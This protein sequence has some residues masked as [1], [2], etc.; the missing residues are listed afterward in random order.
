MFAEPLT[1]NFLTRGSVNDRFFSLLVFLH[2]GLPLLLLLGLWIHIQRMSRPDTR[3][4]LALGW[5]ATL[6]LLAL[7]LA[8]PVE[9]LASGRISRNAPQ[10]LQFDW[11]YLAPNAL[12]YYVVGGHAVVARGRRHPAACWCALGCRARGG[13]R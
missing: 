7:S 8:A 2:I 1:R 10:A 6:A 12:M 13:S 11:F 3:P 5:G 9:S 4:A